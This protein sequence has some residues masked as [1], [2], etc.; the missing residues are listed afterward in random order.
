MDFKEFLNKYEN[1]STE[2]LKEM[3]TLN[4]TKIIK[5]AIFE[6]TQNNTTILEAIQSVQI[7]KNG[8]DVIYE[9]TDE[10]YFSCKSIF[11]HFDL[12]VM[13]EIVDDI[14]ESNSKEFDKK[15]KNLTNFI[16]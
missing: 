15:L 12:L 7:I 8:F 9:I 4:I 5:R 13:S 6:G 1:K 11:K 3:G 2:E 10:Y 16:Y 14:L